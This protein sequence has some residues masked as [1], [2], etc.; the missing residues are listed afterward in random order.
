M[1]KRILSVLVVSMLTSAAIM[2]GCG[3]M[4]VPDVTIKVQETTMDSANQDTKAETEEADEGTPKLTL[5]DLSEANSLDK[6]FSNHK[7]WASEVKVS[8]DNSNMAVKAYGLYG[9]KVYSENG[10]TCFESDFL[11]EDGVSHNL[12]SSIFNGETDYYLDPEDDKLMTVGWYVMSDDEK[13][14]VLISKYAHPDCFVPFVYIEEAGE[15]IDSI[16]DNDDGTLTL[17]TLSPVEKATEVINL[18]AELK[19]GDARY[20]YTI[21]KDTLEVTAIVIE[22]VVGEETY[23]LMTE[24]IFYDVEPPEVYDNMCELVYSFK[25][26]PPKNP[27]TLTVIYDPDTDDEESF[28]ITVDSDYRISTAIR[29]G[30]SLYKDPK[31]NVPFE[32]SDGKSDVTMFAIKD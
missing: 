31:G 28:R 14:D 8:E 10:V 24:K 23:D 15:T 21:D 4:E 29:E 2:S 30:Y 25:N 12:Q 5:E 9:F 3:T 20:T 19:G 1:R 13:K 7:N 26:D 6:I 22:I 27:K 11:D 16:Q 32:G 17:I 18:P